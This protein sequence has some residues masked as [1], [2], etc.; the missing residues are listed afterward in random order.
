M[1]IDTHAHIMFPEFAS[2]LDAVF[3]KAKEA[4]LKAIINVGC[5]KEASR[6]AFEMLKDYDGR[7]GIALYATLG[8]HP[9]DV[10][11]LSDEL[12]VEWE[13]M[14]GEAGGKIVAI[15]EIGLD[16]FKAEVP[17]DVQA[18][19]FKKQLEFALKMGLPV[20]VHNREADEDTLKILREFPEIRAVFHCYGSN[21][22]FA[23]K[24]WELGYYTSFTGIVT[25]PK[26]L[27]VQEVARECPS[28]KFMVETDCPFLAPQIYRGKRNEPS[29]VSE[30]LR[31]VA[32]LKGASFE[33]ATKWQKENAKRFYGV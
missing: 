30:V 24:L 7:H 21:L 31:E 18:D 17:R 20:V 33:E 12:L 32:K 19:A 9:Y 23:K 29:Y 22:E 28:D 10:A 4:G 3:L 14:I 25:Y 11:D 6:Q 8:L 1:L 13:K 2:D 16:Y 26:A 5:S 15:G 27:N